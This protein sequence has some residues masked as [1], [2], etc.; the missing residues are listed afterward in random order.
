[1]VSKEKTEA[2]ARNLAKSITELIETEEAY[3]K[4]LETMV[5]VRQAQEADKG[6]MLMECR[7]S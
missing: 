6:R 7:K 5:E 2:M 3:V 1:M 4:D